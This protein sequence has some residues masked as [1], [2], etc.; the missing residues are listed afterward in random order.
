MWV[1]PETGERDEDEVVGWKGCSLG[2]VSEV[3][4]M[5]MGLVGLGDR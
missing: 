1:E 2:V 3:M 5:E 4:E